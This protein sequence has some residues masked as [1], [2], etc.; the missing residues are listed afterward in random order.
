MDGSFPL[1]NFYILAINRGIW[2]YY[3]E[4][5]EEMNDF[6]MLTKYLVDNV[7]KTNESFLYSQ[8]VDQHID[9]DSERVEETETNLVNIY[10][11]ELE[12]R[13]A[14][15]VYGGDIVYQDEAHRLKNEIDSIRLEILRTPDALFTG[16]DEYRK[17]EH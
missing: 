17:Y 16:Y 14:Q 7:A 6:F 3:A 11:D 4:I 13:M 9:N 8:T 12:T 5:T 2:K 1:K 15:T 10:F